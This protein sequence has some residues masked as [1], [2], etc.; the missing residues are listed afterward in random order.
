MI[1]DPPSALYPCDQTGEGAVKCLLSRDSGI[2]VAVCA[3]TSTCADMSV[4][5]TPSSEAKKQ[6]SF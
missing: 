2:E 4:S 5:P 1:Q 3:D 6:L